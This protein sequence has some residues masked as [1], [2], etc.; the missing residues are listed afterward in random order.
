MRCEQLGDAADFAFHGFAAGF[1]RMRGEYR[2]ELK[3]VQQILSLGRTHFV[4]ELVVGAG[5]FVH[6]VDGLGFIYGGLTAVQHG[7]A[8]VLLA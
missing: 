2:V 6:W 4:N 8:V 3:L 1:S 7:D 5:H